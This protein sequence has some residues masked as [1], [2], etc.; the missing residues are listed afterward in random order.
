MD[1][2]ATTIAK[3]SINQTLLFRAGR[4]ST[5]RNGGPPG[6]LGGVC[7]WASLARLSASLMRLMR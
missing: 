2:T 3:S 1:A 4:G 6:S 7:C 5:G